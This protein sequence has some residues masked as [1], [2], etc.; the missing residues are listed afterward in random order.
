MEII[1]R[2]RNTPTGFTVKVG[3]TNVRVVRF[4]PN[5]KSN[6]ALCIGCVFRGEGARFCEYAPACMA[7]MRPDHESVV[8]AETSN[9]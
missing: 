6:G 5:I 3:G 4:N 1:N 9:V 7:H 2:L 8:F